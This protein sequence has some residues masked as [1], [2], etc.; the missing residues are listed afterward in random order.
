MFL[1]GS[2]KA[3][4]GGFGKEER[5]WVA[6]SEIPRQADRCGAEKLTT[7]AMGEEIEMVKGDG[8]TK[9]MSTVW[10]G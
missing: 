9:E 8:D 6:R 5:E 2:L 1:V 4:G 3:V 7:G 10:F